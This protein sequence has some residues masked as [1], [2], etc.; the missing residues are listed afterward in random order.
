MPAAK[1]KRN[2]EIIQAY[3]L[4]MPVVQIAA[5][6]GISKQRASQIA[7]GCAYKRSNRRSLVVS[8]YHPA[9]MPIEHLVA[10]VAKALKPFAGKVRARAERERA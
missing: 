2:E 7:R 3:R 4:G 5:I 1:V 9:D 10:K 6:Y 8:V